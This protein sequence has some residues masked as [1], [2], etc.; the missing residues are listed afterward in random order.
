MRLRSTFLAAL[1]VCLFHALPAT[2]DE[3]ESIAAVKAAVA[4]IEKAFAEQDTATIASM[5]TPDHI[6]IATRYG[7]AVR[8][9]DQLDT[10]P[11]LERTTSGVSPLKVTL[12]REDAA[13][14]NYEQTY[15]GTYDGKALP[16]RVAVSQI[17]LKQDGDWRQLLYQET[18]IAP[19]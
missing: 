2:A 4:K 9:P 5:F 13:L 6:S 14:V 11:V 1:A 7:G 15:S 16:S 8:L 19:P 10:I 18:P 12:F 17:W 3:A